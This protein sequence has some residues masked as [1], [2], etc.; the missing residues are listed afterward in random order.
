MSKC[1]SRKVDIV[2]SEKIENYKIET[3]QLIFLFFFSIFGEKNKIKLTLNIFDLSNTKHILNLELLIIP[4]SV[5]FNSSHL[6]FVCDQ[7]AIS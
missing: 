3:N 2:V 5:T 7:M 4:N 1:D 6:Q